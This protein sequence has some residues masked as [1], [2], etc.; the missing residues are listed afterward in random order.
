MFKL[1]GYD[2]HEWTL[3]SVHHTETLARDAYAAA[4]TEHVWERLA[5]AWVADGE[6]LR[7]VCGEWKPKPN[8][9]VMEATAFVRAARA[10][11]AVPE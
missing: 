8:E 3:I 9:K 2:G 11:V 7:M 4:L 1:L 6:A 5:V 10:A